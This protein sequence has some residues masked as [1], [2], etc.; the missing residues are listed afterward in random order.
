MKCCPHPD[1]DDDG[2]MCQTCFE[3]YRINDSNS[4]GAIYARVSERDHCADALRYGLSNL[5][6]TAGLEDEDRLLERPVGRVRYAVWAA[7][8]AVV[9]VGV[10]Y[11]VACFMGQ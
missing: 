10:A 5:F 1:W 7:G 4:D 2:L 9:V 8:C 11:L 6:Y 3:T